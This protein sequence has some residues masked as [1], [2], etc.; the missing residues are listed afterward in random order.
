M[1]VPRAGSDGTDCSSGCAALTPLLLPGPRGRARGSKPCLVQT[2]Q[3]S[4]GSPRPQTTDVRKLRRGWHTQKQTSLS[5]QSPS[6]WCAGRDS[7]QDTENLAQ[8]VTGPRHHPVLDWPS[9]ALPVMWD[10]IFY[11]PLAHNGQLL[12]ATIF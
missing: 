2:H 6:G 4:P 5:S 11:Y 12:P 9:T 1:P 8:D 3:S 7:G 10:N